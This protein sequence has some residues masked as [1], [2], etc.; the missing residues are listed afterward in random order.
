MGSIVGISRSLFTATLL[1]SLALAAVLPRTDC[2]SIAAAGPVSARNSAVCHCRNAATE[3]VGVSAVADD[4]D[5]LSEPLS[6]AGHVAVATHQTDSN[7]ATIPCSDSLHLSASLLS[8]G[9]R[10]NC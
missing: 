3:M 2:P 4:S 10:L 5:E 8:Q 9:T 6:P 7:V 1:A